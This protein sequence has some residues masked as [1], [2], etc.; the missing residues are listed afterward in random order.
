MEIIAFAQNYIVT[1]L[2]VLTV[3][4]FVHEFGHYWVAR[5]C[6]VRVE[7]FSI[8]F[9][10]ELFGWT[11]SHGTRW[12]FSLIPLGGYV[13]M[14]GDSDEASAGISD[15]ARTMTA[16]QRQEAFFAKSVGQRAAI[17]V[18]G[19]AANYIFAILVMASLF[20]AYGQPYTLPQAGE[21]AIEGA[22]ARAGM[23]A[24]DTVTAID[25]SPVTRFEQIQ[26]AVA[27]NTG[28]AMKFDILRDE[29]NMTLI[30]TPTIQET[31]DA[32]GNKHNT[33]RIGISKSGK[34]VIAHS[35]L[36]ALTTAVYES[37]R[38]S[39]DSVLALGQMISGTRS[40]DELGGPLRIAQMSG[41]VAQVG[42][43]ELVW[44]MALL[45]ISLGLL[46]LFPIPMLDGG[47]L[48]YYFFEAVRGKPLSDNLQEYAA[49]GGF[50]F[51]VG[52]MLFATWND[53]VKLEIFTAIKHL[54]T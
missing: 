16:E 25:G 18:A 31:T 11:D 48:L 2:V 1:F 14:Y 43:T 15:E 19:P 12:K 42:L 51:L 22:A 5:R 35:P 46:N 28:T 29:K 17:V 49:R 53:L 3:L 6:G 26:Q 40:A 47:H 4:V 50:A 7:T 27:L 44:F 23:K 39:R 37:W 54:F 20:M 9:G 8:G 33:A 13:K 36:S 21:V 52:I 45:S 41:S 24:G 38:I 30:V 10:R 34:D 32:F